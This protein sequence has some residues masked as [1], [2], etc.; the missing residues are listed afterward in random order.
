MVRAWSHALEGTVSFSVHLWLENHSGL[1]KNM[2][3]IE[4]IQE[5]TVVIVLEK[6]EILCL[7]VNIEAYQLFKTSESIYWD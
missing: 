4:Y 3:I 7:T 2:G 6:N 5:L 1:T